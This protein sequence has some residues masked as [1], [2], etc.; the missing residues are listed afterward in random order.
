MKKKK[1]HKRYIKQLFSADLNLKKM[2]KC[3]WKYGKTT[4]KSGLLIEQLYLELGLQI[5]NMIFSYLLL[6][7][8]IEIT[9]GQAY[10]FSTELSDVLREAV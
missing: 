7:K 2:K 4:L 8:G 9:K 6:F 3:P 10:L 5:W 1:N